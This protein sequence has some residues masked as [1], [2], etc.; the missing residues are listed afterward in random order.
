VGKYKFS[1]KKIWLLQVYAVLATMQCGSAL[2]NQTCDPTWQ[3]IQ[4]KSE[5]HIIAERSEATN[6]DDGSPILS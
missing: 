2:Q 5:G 3:Y 6:L 4:T 1:I